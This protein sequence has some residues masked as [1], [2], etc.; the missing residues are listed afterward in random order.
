MKFTKLTII[1]I[2]LL[3]FAVSVLAQDE[4]PKIVWKNLQEK[5]EKFEDINP[6]LQNEMDESI[7]LARIY[8]LWS[9]RLIG[10][11]EQTQKWENRGG[12]IRICYSVEDALIPIEIKTK[13]SRS[14]SISW[15]SISDYQNLFTENQNKDQDI[16]PIKK[17]KLILDYALEPWTYSQKPKRTYKTVSPQFEVTG[18]E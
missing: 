4:K 6:M 11:N 2:F 18:I 14:V 9:A 12:A 3:V 10:F 5:Y 7:F 13:E 15:E 17:Y 1:F 16:K 8:P